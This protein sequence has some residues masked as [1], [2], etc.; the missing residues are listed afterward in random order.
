MEKVKTKHFQ[1]TGL[2]DY[3]RTLDDQIN[4]FLESENI[5]VERLIGITYFA[6]ST[7]GITYYTALV[8]YKA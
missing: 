3:N 4:I 5:D 7:E 8:V 1:Y 6:H 2:D